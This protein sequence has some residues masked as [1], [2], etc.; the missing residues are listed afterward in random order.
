MDKLKKIYFDMETK[1]KDKPLKFY[2]ILLIL[3]LVF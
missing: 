1:L 2:I 3:S